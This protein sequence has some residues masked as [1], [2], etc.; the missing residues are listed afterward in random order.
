MEPNKG[1][2]NTNKSKDY[3]NISNWASRYSFNE[4]K[5]EINTCHTGNCACLKC[6]PLEDILN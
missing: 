4:G 6:H 3:L 2:N 1:E 5:K